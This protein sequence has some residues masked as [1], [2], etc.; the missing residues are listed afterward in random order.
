MLT[1]KELKRLLKSD[2]QD[3]VEKTIST[4]DTDKFCEA[5]CSFSNDLP[6]HGLPGY[7]LIGVNPDGTASGLKVSEMLLEQL[8]SLRSD[9]N[10]QPF[11]IM[12]VYKLEHPMGTGEIAIVEVNPSELTPVRYRGRT[13]IR[14]G[15]RRGFATLQE[16]RKLT[17]KNTDSAKTF[18]ARPCVGASLNDLSQELF[19]VGYRETAVASEVLAENHRTVDLQLASLRFFNLS[20]SCPTNAGMLLFGKNPLNWFSGAYVEFVRFEGKKLSDN[21]LDNK[22]FSGDLLTVLK[23][24]NSFVSIQIT[25]SVVRGDVLRDKSIKDYPEIAIR[26]IL[27][28]GLMHRDYEAS[29]PVRFYWFED[30]IE[31]QSPGGLYGE[32]TP[33]NF[34]KQNAYRN[35]IIAEAMNNLGYVNKF[36]RG[37]ERAQDSLEK[38]GNPRAQ[39]DFQDTFVLCVIRGKQ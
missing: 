27:M 4:T 15:P 30:R 6:N 33:E 18:D 12:S 23:D 37:V 1:P 20:K 39:F 36:G 32:A 25:K 29:G 35:P 13:C 28:N 7:L 26:E 38:N 24:L 2:E 16:E 11:P 21:V 10:I 9:A 3:R 34:P 19:V 5:I 17:E 22:R 31:I 8:G 14:V